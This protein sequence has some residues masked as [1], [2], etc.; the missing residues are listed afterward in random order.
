MMRVWAYFIDWLFDRRDAGT[1]PV[2]R[3]HSVSS[4]RLHIPRSLMHALRKRTRATTV[5]LEPLV[6]L[7][8]RYASERSTNTM[9]AVD[10]ISFPD[11]AYVEGF[12]G[13][14]FDTSWVVERA[15]EAITAN[16]GLLLVHSHGGPGHPQ[17]SL[18]D[19]RTN[20]EVMAPLAVGAATVPYGAMVLSDVSAHAVIAVSGALHDV[21]VIVVAD[22][23]GAMELTA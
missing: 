7:R 5:R 14:N 6:L 1:V 9:V 17:F 15:N 8:V 19:T 13:A 2:E 20:R 10:A 22:H 4:F 3:D 16:A 21:R 18:V 23:L 12:A 11:H